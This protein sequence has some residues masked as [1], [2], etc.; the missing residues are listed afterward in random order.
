MINR[1]QSTDILVVDG[2]IAA[3]TGREDQGLLLLLLLLA[4]WLL[5]WRV[6][7]GWRSGSRTT[8]VRIDLFIF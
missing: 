6:Q 5:D 3:P 1:A 7:G 2:L 4:L 8:H